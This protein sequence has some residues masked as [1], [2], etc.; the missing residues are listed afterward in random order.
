VLTTRHQAVTW[1]LGYVAFAVL[2][3][4]IAARRWRGGG[5]A[6]AP[7]PAEGPPPGAGRPVGAAPA[8]PTW[9]DRLLWAALPAC[10]SLL[11]L[12]I[13]KH[14]TEDLAPIPLL[15]VLPLS[16]YLLSFILCFEG[17]PWYHRGL[18]L[19]L[20]ALALADMTW[21]QSQFYGGTSAKA[22][23]AL[24]SL[25]LFVC[26][27]VC[28]GELQRLRPHPRHLTSFYLM[29]STGGALG[30]LFAALV[31]PQV[32]PGYFELPLAFV[33]CAVL[34][35]LALGRDPARVVRAPWRNP[36][37]LLALALTVAMAAYL[38]HDVRRLSARTLLMARNFYGALRVEAFV[39]RS[40][41]GAKLL[42][43]S[44]SHGEQYLSEE[45]RREPTS[46]YA[47]RSGV[48]LAIRE[49]QARPAQRVG[50]IGLGVGTLAAYGRA[51]DV[52]RFY[53]INPLVIRLATSSMFTFLRDSPARVEIAPGDARLTL[54]REGAQGFD[55]LAVDAFTS[56]AIPVHLLTRE[57][58]AVYARHLAPGGVLAVHVSNRYLDLPPVVKQLAREV[59][60]DARLVFAPADATSGG[61]IW[62]LVTG[63]PEFFAHPLLAPAVPIPDRPLRPWTDD[64]SNLFQVLR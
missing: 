10:A 31:A 50:V 15:W 32:F 25:G 57:A 30:G 27:M 2:G 37:W 64:Y 16:L 11:L 36:S 45:G 7:A 13:T 33:L 52:Y 8:T 51:G 4:V 9:A 61:S 23:V 22:P 58:F 3:G 49:G 21:A 46:Y 17:S 14:L 44:T 63:R 43:G 12:A 41:A 28:H 6:P 42:H 62:V 35:L 19:P 54:E 29:V 59:G 1:S 53:E 24:F 60:W 48:A 39:S 40:R 18:F 5:P 56:D 47:P 38:V 34:A 20:L 55:V 26:C